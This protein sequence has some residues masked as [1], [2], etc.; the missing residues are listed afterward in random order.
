MRRSQLKR[1]LAASPRAPMSDAVLVAAAG[2]SGG[3]GIGLTYVLQ[4]I[5]AAAAAA[6]CSQL[7]TCAPCDPC[8]E[9]GECPACPVCRDP[10]QFIESERSRCDA[11]IEQILML[12]VVLVT[13]YALFISLF[14]MYRRLARGMQFGGVVAAAGE[15]T[16]VRPALCI[17]IPPTA[18]GARPALGDGTETPAS[19]QASTGAGSHL[20]SLQW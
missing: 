10:L 7:N 11:R 13:S 2:A 4:R 16:R 6:F 18:R 20:D 1:K 9:C 8:A 14:V 15:A 17:Q 3:A 5:A 12:Y 19:S